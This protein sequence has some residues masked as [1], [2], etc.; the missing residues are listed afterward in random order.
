MHSS[1]DLGDGESDAFVQL[2]LRAH[3]CSPVTIERHGNI[4][5]NSDLIKDRDSHIQIAYLKKSR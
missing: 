5:I 2:L 3:G 1:V 4:I